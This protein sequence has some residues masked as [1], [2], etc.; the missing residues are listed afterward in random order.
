MQQQVIR[1]R[2]ERPEKKGKKG[3][4]KQGKERKGFGRAPAHPKL[5]PEHPTSF[6]QENKYLDHDSAVRKAP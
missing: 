3:K 2:S 1:T 4:K 6:G 5:S